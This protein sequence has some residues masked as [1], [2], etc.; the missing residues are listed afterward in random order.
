MNA[1]LIIGIIIAIVIFGGGVYYMNSST[2]DIS[3]EDDSEPS[4]EGKQFVIELSDS[5]Q[6]KGT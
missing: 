5:V 4:T 2:S 6:M 1:K 3:I